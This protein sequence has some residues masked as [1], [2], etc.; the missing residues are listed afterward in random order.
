MGARPDADEQLA[1]VLASVRAA[2]RPRT[3]KPPP[4]LAAVDPVAQ[5]VVDVPLLHLDRRFE[6]AVPAPLAETALPGVRVKVRFA[7]RDRDGFVVARTAVAEHTGR[8]APLRRVVS[9]EPVLTEAT[10]RLCR[11]V[12]DR[13]AGSLSDT[14]RLAIPPR[15][16]QAEQAA[17]SQSTPAT[18]PAQPAPGPWATY[19]GGAAFLDRL[20][21]GQAPRAAWLATPAAGRAE[22]DWPTAVALAVRCLLSSGRGA[23]VVLPDARDVARMDAALRSLDGNGEPR[24]VVLTADLGP[25]ARYAAWLRVLRGQVAA[26]VGTRAAMF[27]PVRD[28]GLVVCWD[29]G[30]DLHCEPHAPYPHVREV[31]AMRA[32]LE[33]AAALFGGFVRT[34]EVARMVATG[35]AR[36]VVAA[37]AQVRL[38]APRVVLAGEG[39]EPERDPGAATARLPSLA[40]RTAAQALRSAPVL[41]QVPR[42]GYVPAVACQTCRTR[43]ACS[44]CH[45]PLM[46]TSGTSQPRCRW[47]GLNVADW[48]CPE[49]GDHRLR[50]VV[51][52]ARRTAEELGRAFPGTPV[53]TSGGAQVLATVPAQPCLVVATPGAEPVAEGGYG[54]ALLLDPWALL[55]RSDLR[56]HEEAFRRWANA[57]ALVRGAADGGTVVLAGPGGL[58]PVEALVRWGPQWHSERELAGRQELG[59]PPASNVTTLTGEAAAVDDLV[60]ELRLPDGVEVLGPVPL[61]DPLVRVLL[62]TT[63]TGRGALSASLR[64]ALAI[65]SAHK[66]A[67]VVRVQVDP[68]DLV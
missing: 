34:A 55:A 42:G 62:R 12:S 64:T 26:V 43:A 50:S 47:C 3:P 7:G 36:S 58:P 16:A 17:T 11:A 44:A 35:W 39:N 15:H 25:K 8:L 60:R 68:L 1:L 52:G 40:W 53:R 19:Q 54:A 37:P 23:L 65:R 22:Q 14:L 2:A 41:I 21:A 18:A 20:A 28:L 51:V 9:S 56:A 29:D 13:W 57:A 46:L 45:G 67:G 61:A 6:Y 49:C 4:G 30:D 10:L 5:V 38:A 31:L 59:F 24:H 32:E 27:A 48:S 66:R 33:G 63:P